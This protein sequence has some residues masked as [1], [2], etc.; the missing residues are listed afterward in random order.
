MANLLPILLIGGGAL[1][2][3]GKKKKRRKKAAEAP[4]GPDIPPFPGEEEA[5][6]EGEEGEGPPGPG[7]GEAPGDTS[8][9]TGTDEPPEPGK[10][11]A[12]GIEMHRTGAYPWKILFTEQSDYAAHSYPMGHRGPHE[13]VARGA[14]IEEAIAA[15]KSWAENED[16]RKRN[17]PPVITTHAKVTPGDEPARASFQDQEQEDEDG[18]GDVGS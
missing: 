12:S 13:E 11:V 3:A 2:L 4:P 8:M 5:E 18:F 14:T 10:S 16:R 15:F 9:T 17:L 7:P 6:G 1:L